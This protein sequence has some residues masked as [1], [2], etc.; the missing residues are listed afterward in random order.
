MIDS[1]GKLLILETKGENYPGGK[2]QR[3][4]IIM[5]SIFK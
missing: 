5:R 2:L 3:H 4:E 1:S